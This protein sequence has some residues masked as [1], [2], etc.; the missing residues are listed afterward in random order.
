LLPTHGTGP[1]RRGAG[2]RLIAVLAVLGVL[3]AGCAELTPAELRRIE[4]GGT[5]LRPLLD[6][7]SIA[8]P[9][10]DS[11]DI[12]AAL[13]EPDETEEGEPPEGQRPGTVI[14]MRYDGLEIVVRELSE[15]ARAF[16]SDMTITSDEYVTSLPV[17][18][19]ASRAEIEKALGEEAE[20]GE[21]VES[22]ESASGTE[23]VYRL[24]DDGD[25]CIVTYEGER[26]SRMRF[27]F[28]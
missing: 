25:R 3:V 16:I 27:T 4:R 28:S 5:S 22:S 11:A 14:A 19:G 8:I 24:N 6:P 20:T 23:V 18:V 1:Y 15:P 17:R 21:G 12:I 9:G 26:A 13:G 2:R 10:T 7:D